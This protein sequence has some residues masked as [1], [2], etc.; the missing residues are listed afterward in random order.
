MQIPRPLAS[1]RLGM[2]I[3]KSV[4]GR[5]DIRGHCLQATSV[6][7]AQADMVQKVGR[8]PEMTLAA[9]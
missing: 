4:I 9:G 2:T 5:E 3:Q 7:A 1:L 8:P 6:L